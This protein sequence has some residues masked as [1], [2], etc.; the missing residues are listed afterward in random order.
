MREIHN[1]MPVILSRELEEAWLMENDTSTLQSMLQPFDA[2]QMDFY[3]VSKRLNSPVNND[4]DVC[5]QV[6]N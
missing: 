1:R 4:P 6:K 2:R 3:P 5:A